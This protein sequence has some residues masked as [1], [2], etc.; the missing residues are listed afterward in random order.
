MPG[1]QRYE[2]R[3]ISSLT[4][5]VHEVAV[6]SAEIK[7]LAANLD[8]N[9]TVRALAGDQGSP[10]S[11]PL[12]TCTRPPVPTPPQFGYVPMI[13]IPPDLTLQWNLTTL[14]TG[15]H[16][17]ANLKVDLG[18][19]KADGAPEVMQENL[20][21]IDKVLIPIGQEARTFVL[22][23]KGVNPLAPGGSNRS[24]W[25]EAVTVA[26]MVFGE[27]R[28]PGVTETHQLSTNMLR[29]YYGHT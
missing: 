3:L 15:V 4:N 9:V 1:S 14:A 7:N 13:E 19:I 25:S 20:G 10:W 5:T 11:D 2:L 24:V 28:V 8:Y 23:L 27:L 26:P 21:L 16:Q 17:G 6:E 22:R 18:T 29:G 12:L